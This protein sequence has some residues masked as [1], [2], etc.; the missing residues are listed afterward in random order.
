MPDKP[1]NRKGEKKF[2]PRSSKVLNRSSIY[3]EIK[4]CQGCGKQ[5]QRRKRFSDNKVWQE[6]RY[7]SKRCIDS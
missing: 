7:C 2:D 1:Q 6:V 3:T 4:V 5:F